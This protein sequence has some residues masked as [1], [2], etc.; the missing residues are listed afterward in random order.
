LSFHFKCN[1]AKNIQFWS[2][3][4]FYLVSELVPAAGNKSRNVWMLIL[5]VRLGHM[6]RCLLWEH[7]ILIISIIHNKEKYLNHRYENSIFPRVL[8]RIFVPKREEV[9]GCWRKL[10]NLYSS[11]NIVRMIKSRRM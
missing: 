5:Y 2:Y 6:P 8:R 9:T 4:H 11:P 10:H 1:G 7:H 3:L